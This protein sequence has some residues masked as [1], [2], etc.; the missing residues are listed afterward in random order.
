MNLKFTVF[1]RLKRKKCACCCCRFQRDCDRTETLIYL[2]KEEMTQWILPQPMVNER[3]V[4]FF[5][6]RNAYAYDSLF[7]CMYVSICEY[8][9]CCVKKI[10]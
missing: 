1:R 6:P 5:F 3:E 9:E 8:D 10:T 7:I 4:V 2:C